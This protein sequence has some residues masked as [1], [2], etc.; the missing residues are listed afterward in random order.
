MNPDSGVQ[1]FTTYIT[2]MADKGV[3]VVVSPATTSDPAGKQWM[4][5][6]YQKCGPK[7]CGVSK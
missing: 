1:L 7:R 2:P 6:F 3:P 4:I 5:E